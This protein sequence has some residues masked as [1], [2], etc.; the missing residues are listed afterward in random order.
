[1]KGREEEGKQMNKEREHDE[2]G[3]RYCTEAVTLTES[4]EQCTRE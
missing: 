4:T 3:M 1:M 2:E